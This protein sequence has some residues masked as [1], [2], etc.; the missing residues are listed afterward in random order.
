MNINEF[1]AKKLGE[2]LAFTRVSIDTLNK[3]KEALVEALGAEKVQDMIEKNNL[4][5]EEVIRLS[6]EGGAV[7]TTLAKASKT[8]EKLKSMRELYVG[9]EWDNAT[10]LLEWSGF[11]E[12]A[13][14]VH[15]ALVRGTGESM[16]NENLIT[17]ANEAIA[18]H[19][20][21]LEQSESELATIG[22]DK[23]Q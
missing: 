2:V 8:E 14:I 20:E 23:S 3:G 12:G 17:L 19:Y 22:Q 13:A 21:L 11:F 5:G 1:T 16:N 9:D 7:D 18:Y 6:T 4:H 10:E 15:W